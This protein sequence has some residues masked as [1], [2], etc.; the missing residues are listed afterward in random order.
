MSRS[1][2]R[3]PGE[4]LLEDFIPRLPAELQD[5]SA[6]A[7]R[8]GISR[9]RWNEILNGRRAI[10]PDTALRL[11]R[12]FGVLPDYWMELQAKWELRAEMRSRRTRAEIDWIRPVELSAPREPV[13]PGS[14]KGEAEARPE[15]LSMRLAAE[16]IAAQPPQPR[17]LPGPERFFEGSPRSP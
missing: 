3:S 15:E 13:S 11:G 1:Q 2:L 4:V 9:Q 16:V 12:F 17:P 6:V 8:L 7:R 14:W 10:T 5:Q